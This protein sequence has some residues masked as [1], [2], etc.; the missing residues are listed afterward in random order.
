MRWGYVGGGVLILAAFISALMVIGFRI[1]A[2]EDKIDSFP[3]ASISEGA[4]ELKRGVHNVYVDAP[5]AAGFGW[6]LAIRDPERREVPLRRAGTTFEYSLGDREGTLVGKITV[7][8][9][10]RHLIT[11]TGPPG[12]RVIFG[13]GVIRGIFGAVLLGLGILVVLGGAG[14]ALIVV[15]AARGRPRE[16]KRWP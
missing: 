14:L 13:R 8:T 4:V 7:T 1:L 16:Q 5:A 11:G 15:T 12:T 9:P 10:G 6:T 3:K 2:L